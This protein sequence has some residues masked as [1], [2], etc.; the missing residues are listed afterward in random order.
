MSKLALGVAGQWFSGL[1]WGSWSPPQ[2][3]AGIVLRS[4][5]LEQTAEAGVHIL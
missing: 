5:L 1:F 3:K 4:E 2:I